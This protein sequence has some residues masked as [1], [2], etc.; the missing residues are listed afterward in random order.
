MKTTSLGWLSMFS[1]IFV[2]IIF[3][4]HVRQD[5]RI[6]SQERVLELMVYYEGALRAAVQDA[7]V[8]LGYNERE[9]WEE[10]IKYDSDKKIRPDKERA[11]EAFLRTLHIHFELLD[12]PAGQQALLRYLPAFA[13]IDYDGFWIYAETEYRN[14]E[15]ETVIGH[16]WQPKKPY[17]YVDASGNSLSFTLDGYVHVYRKSDGTWHEGLRE[18][19][20]AETEG[21]IP[22]LGNPELFEQVRR[23]TI[24]RMIQNELQ[25]FINTHNSFSRR[26]GIAYTFT[27]P[28]ISQ[29]DWNN[30]IN[31]V[32][33]LAFLQGIPAGTEAYNNYAFGGGRLVKKHD[34]YGAVRHGRKIYYRSG[35]EEPHDTLEE[36]FGSEKEAAANGYYPEP[37]NNRY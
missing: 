27:L 22:L 7:A 29:E 18:E 17:A 16:V 9:R 3:P 23:A 20:D 14:G 24:V 8:A 11:I 13:V 34:I 37:C 15:N 6:H 4:M 26:L 19:V 28:A 10:E 36:I 1:L 30:S 35:C 2:I 32:G 12:D 5:V 21:E 25:H 33:I 31:D